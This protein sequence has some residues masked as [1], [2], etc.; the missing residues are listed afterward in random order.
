MRI[1]LVQISSKLGNVEQNIIRHLSF[2]EKARNLNPDL[3]IFPELSITGYVP[4]QVSQL[5]IELNDH[6]L[7]PLQ[8]WSD[9]AQ[10]TLGVGLPLKAE[11]GIRIA[12]GLI[13]PG[14]EGNEVY[15]KQYLHPD[16]EP[17]F[18]SG[19]TPQ[20]LFILQTNAIALAICY[21]ISVA[22]HLKSVLTGAPV[23]YIASVAK[24][25]HGVRAAYPKLESIA[26]QNAL[27]TFFCN[28]V[29]ECEDFIAAG[30][31]AVW[32]QNGE[33]VGQMDTQHEG[34]LIYDTQSLSLY[35]F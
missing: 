21:E 29:G 4:N 23:I 8:S 6:Q 14:N 24:S 27:L 3:L 18:I 34:G 10:C 33:L 35:R 11:G 9:T 26:S 2:A 32:N 13:K 16:E 5:A 12:M 25:E 19:P 15:Y 1:G 20:S 17:F 28:A 30:K 31:S 22:D 7:L